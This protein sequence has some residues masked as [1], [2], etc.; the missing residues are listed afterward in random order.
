MPPSQAVTYGGSAVGLQTQNH[1]LWESQLLKQKKPMI[2]LESPHLC[3]RKCPPPP[4][5]PPL[6]YHG[7]GSGLGPK[8]AETQR[9]RVCT[10]PRYRTEH[11]QGG[12]A[13]PRPTATHPPTISR[14]P[15]EGGGRR[16]FPGG[17]PRGHGG[18]GFRASTHLPWFD[19]GGGG[20]RAP[21]NSWVCGP[22]VIRPFAPPLTPT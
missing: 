3:L 1:N 11:T 2:Q 13:R 8:S 17:G 16:F 4:P 14:N 22:R 19:R 9:H 12:V 7:P 6:S 5:R 20:G 18:G 10:S 21:P 15:G